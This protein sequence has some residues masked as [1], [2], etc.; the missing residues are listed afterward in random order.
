M[1]FWQP[2]TS[3]RAHAQ[4]GVPALPPAVQDAHFNGR[5]LVPQPVTE[6]AAQNRTGTSAQPD[7]DSKPL[8]T[9]SGRVDAAGSAAGRTGARCFS[10]R[11]LRSFT[12]GEIALMLPCLPL[13]LPSCARPRLSETIVHLAPTYATWTSRKL[14]CPRHGGVLVATRCFRF[15]LNLLETS[16]I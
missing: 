16:S 5:Q 14:C 13:Q 3:V 7:M 2:I 15:L 1:N 6:R 8:E 10:P 11:L 9:L 4:C 12:G